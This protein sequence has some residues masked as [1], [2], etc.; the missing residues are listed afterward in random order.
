MV[1]L[2]A[3]GTVVPPGSPPLL[4]AMRVRFSHPGLPPFHLSSKR[5]QTVRG[6]LLETKYEVLLSAT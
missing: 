4:F 3:S 6:A 2:A 5:L 1:V